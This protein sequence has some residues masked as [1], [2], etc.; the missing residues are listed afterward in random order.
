VNE[1][2]I[3]VIPKFFKFATFSNYLLAILNYDFILNSVCETQSFL[4]IIAIP[5]FLLEANKPSVFLMIN[6]VGLRN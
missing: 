2:F 3:C 1:I 4:S 5:T 6:Q